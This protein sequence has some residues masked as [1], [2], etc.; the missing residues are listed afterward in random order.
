[1]DANGLRFWMLA[2]ETHWRHRVN[3]HYDSHKQVLRLA[4]RRPTRHI[5]PSPA[6]LG[7]AES[8]LAI[9]PQTRD[10]F[11]HR[12]W[13]DSARQAIVATGA[14]EGVVPIG[15]PTADQPPT[16]LAMGYDDI[17]YVA[18]QGKLILYDRRHRTAPVTIDDPRMIAWRLAAHPDGGLWILDRTNRNVWRL[19]PVSPVRRPFGDYAPTTFRPCEEGSHAHALTLA[20][21]P[22]WSEGEDPVAIAC[23]T[24]GDVGILSWLSD[25][26]AHIRIRTADGQDRGPTT[27][28]SAR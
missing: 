23:N 6:W 11:G 27:L 18:V 19:H 28:D 14:G 4:E 20:L 1:M 7:I 17:L 21:Q 22:L 12:A 25:G 8:R 15:F 26:V 13:W 5:E 2:D 16:D 10:A 9:V 24:R 3:V